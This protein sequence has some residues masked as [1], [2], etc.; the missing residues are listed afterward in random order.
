MPKSMCMMPSGLAD[1][2]PGAQAANSAAAAASAWPPQYMPSRSQRPP[3]S[4]MP[5]MPRPSTGSSPMGLMCRPAS[6]MSIPS[7][8]M[9]MLGL[10]ERCAACW[11]WI[12]RLASYIRQT[13]SRLRRAA[14]DHSSMTS[15]KSRTA[16]ICLSQSGTRGLPHCQKIDTSGTMA[17][18]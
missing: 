6:D 9:C 12:A 4:S 1:A 13:T 18:W 11:A 10:W 14:S 16:S 8:V 3:W 7:P 5:I 15:S 2:G 17:A